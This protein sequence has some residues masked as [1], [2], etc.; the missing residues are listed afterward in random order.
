MEGQMPG[1]SGYEA[2][3]RIRKLPDPLKSGIKIIALTASA[4]TG[5]RQRCLEAG[6]DGYLSKVSLCWLRF[7]FNFHR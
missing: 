3:S 1:L 5:D 4:F 2:T 6:M 7:V